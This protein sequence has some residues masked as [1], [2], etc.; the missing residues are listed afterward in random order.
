MLRRRRD[1]GPDGGWWYLLQISLWGRLELPG[2]RVV[3]EPAPVET[4]AP[5]E[6]C[7][8]LDGQD[9]AEVPTER[10]DHSSAWLL[11][12]PVGG[13]EVLVVHR[14]DCAAP[15]GVTRPA[16][17]EEV[18]QAVADGAVVCPVCRPPGL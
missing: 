17:V 10:P 13:G 18:R 2:G 7:E 8:P 4:W 15:R 5:A 16:A 3:A 1:P 9:Y 11:E 6:V 12:E 14:G